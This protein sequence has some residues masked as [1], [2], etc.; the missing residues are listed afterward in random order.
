MPN[1]KSISKDMFVGWE[2]YGDTLPTTESQ[3]L[4]SLAI[5]TSKCSSFGRILNVVAVPLDES[6]MSK[7]TLEMRELMKKA[8]SIEEIEKILAPIGGV[9]INV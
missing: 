7:V 3:P 2:F 5:G 6:R 4:A 8:T 1:G 9:K